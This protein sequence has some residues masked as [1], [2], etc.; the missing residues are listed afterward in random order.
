MNMENMTLEDCLEN[1][2]RKGKATIINDG[3]VVGFTEE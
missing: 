2:E 1:Y 3:V